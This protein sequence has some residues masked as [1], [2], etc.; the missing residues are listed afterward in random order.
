MEEMSK[1]DISS[2]CFK[3]IRRKSRFSQKLKKLEK[4]CCDV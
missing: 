4:G 3:K 2:E 1:N